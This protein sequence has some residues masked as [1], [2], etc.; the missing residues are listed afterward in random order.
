MTETTP[1]HIPL[2]EGFIT[3]EFEDGRLYCYEF[4]V[5]DGVA[6]IKF[7]FDSAPQHH[8]KVCGIEMTVYERIFSPHSKNK[9]TAWTSGN[10]HCGVTTLQYE[11]QS[12]PAGP[13]RGRWKRDIPALANV[14]VK[15]VAVA[16]R[17]ARAAWRKWAIHLLE[18]HYQF[19]LYR[20]HRRSTDAMEGF[21]YLLG[22]AQKR[23]DRA[24]ELFHGGNIVE[25][26]DESGGD[27]W[28]EVFP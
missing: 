21:R 10:S 15:H 3:G 28:A 7:S 16:V 1:L 17:E 18:T 4:H 27:I 5:G 13:G 11:G 24:V 6:E 22:L 14:P 2:Q 8:P 9:K 26:V 23:R 20:A 25:K 12:Y 19:D